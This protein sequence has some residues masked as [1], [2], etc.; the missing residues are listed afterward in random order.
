MDHVREGPFIREAHES[1]WPLARSAICFICLSLTKLEFV[2][3][4]NVN[5]TYWIVNTDM[6][7]VPDGEEVII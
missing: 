2:D 6:T 1:L 4:N 7:L 3:I 5:V